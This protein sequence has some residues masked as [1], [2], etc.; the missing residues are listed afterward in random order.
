MKDLSIFEELKKLETV[1][2]RDNKDLLKNLKEEQKGTETKEI[3]GQVF[4]VTGN[5]HELKDF[6]KKVPQIKNILCDDDVAEHLIDLSKHG[7]LVDMLPNL[8]T[9]NKIPIPN[10]YDAYKVEKEILEVLQHLWKYA[11]TY[12]YFYF[13]ISLDLAHQTIKKIKKVTG[14]LW[15]K[16]VAL[17]ST[18]MTLT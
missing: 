11:C 18:A 6:F 15:M 3:E 10:S 17:F 7:K 8:E 14:T 16:L 1:D 2:I 5:S 4:N 13:F 12:R 9:I